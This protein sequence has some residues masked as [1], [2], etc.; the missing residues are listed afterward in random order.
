MAVSKDDYKHFVKTGKVSDS[1]LNDIAEKV[2]THS[3]LTP[4]E[5]SI[6]SD[7]TSQVESILQKQYSS[8][9]SPK[10]NSIFS[11]G[12]SKPL[13]E[14]SS[15]EELHKIA[16]A[17]REQ[18]PTGPFWQAFKTRKRELFLSQSPNVFLSKTGEELYGIPVNPRTIQTSLG[19]ERIK[20]DLYGQLFTRKQL[21][22]ID[23][24]SDT[25]NLTNKGINYSEF[26]G[27]QKQ[28]AAWIGFDLETTGLLKD[29]SNKRLG[30]H[31]G[32]L[33]M[34]TTIGGSSGIIEQQ[35]HLGT[36]DPNRPKFGD[37][38][39]GSIIPK[40]LQLQ[41]E[42]SIAALKKA[43]VNVSNNISEKDI[44]SS[45]IG[46]LEKNKNASLLGYNIKNFDIPFMEKIAE[47]HGLSGQLASAMGNRNVIDVADYAKAFLSERFYNKYVG[48]QEGSFSQMGRNPAGWQLE[49]VAHGFGFDG[50]TGGAHT[51]LQDTLMTE[52]VYKSLTGQNP[53][54][55]FNEQRYLEKMKALGNELTPMS[56]F[57]KLTTIKEGKRY[58]S[59]PKEAIPPLKLGTAGEEIRESLF[60]K[61]KSFALKNKGKLAIGVGLLAVGGLLFS[62]KD[63]EYN[64]IEALQHGNMAEGIRRT[65]T[66]FGSGYR[67]LPSS[68]MGVEIDP[69]ILSYKRDIIQTGKYKDVEA[70]L[71]RREKEQQEN[72]GSL[73]DSDFKAKRDLNLDT[74]IGINYRNRRLRQV[75]LEQFNINV[76]DAD[77]LVLKRK[78]IFG[79]F[80]KDI[81]IR[82][83][84]IDAPESASHEADPL[85]PV[86]IWQE[87][88]EAEES[89]EKLR[90]LIAQQKNLSLIVGGERTYGRY[91]GALIGDKSALNIDLASIGAV[92]AL[93]FGSESEDVLSRTLIESE[94]KKAQR[95]NLGIWSLARYK[96][97]DLVQDTIR[98]PI[99]FN[100]ITRIDKMAQ[101]LNLAAYGSFLEDLGTERRNLT[102]D[103]RET[104]KRIG[105]VLRKTHGP[106]KRYYNQKEGL[107][108][109][110][111]G[112][113]AKMI[114]GLT[115]FGSNS[116]ITAGLG[117]VSGEIAQK[118]TM[119]L[120]RG[121]AKKVKI[122]KP[123]LS[124]GLNK[125]KQELET[126]IERIRK[127]EFPNRPSRLSSS[128]WS[129]QPSVASAY[130]ANNRTRYTF[131]GRLKEKLSTLLGKPSSGFISKRQVDPNDIFMTSIS[132]YGEAMKAYNMKNQELLLEA[133]RKYWKGITDFAPEDIASNK[134]VLEVL[135]PNT[136]KA[137]VIWPLQDFSIKAHAD[138]AV[139]SLEASILRGQKFSGMPNSGTMAAEIREQLTEFKKDFAS[140]WDPARNIAASVFKGIKGRKA[141]NLL[142]KTEEWKTML[143]T[144]EQLKE[145]SYG[146]YGTT[147]LMEGTFRGEKFK[148]VKKVPNTK[149]VDENSDFLT[150]GP[151]KEKRIAALKKEASVMPIVQDRI[152]PS[153]YGFDEETNALYMELM[154]G[155]TLHELHQ[156]GTKIPINK[157]L[158]EI[159]QEAKKVAKQGV[160]NTDIHSNNIMYDP[161]TGK[162]SW[163]DWG[164]A[165]SSTGSSKE[166]LEKN[167]AEMAEAITKKLTPQ[168]KAKINPKRE[169]EGF[170]EM[171]FGSFNSM[172]SKAKQSF[173]DLSQNSVGV[174]FR[175]SR[176]AIKHG[177]YSSVAQ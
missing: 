47:R 21:E 38:I 150:G 1:I 118:M 74:I 30:S 60:S 70:E 36:L 80:S 17:G 125:G 159:K 174:S 22:G 14:A 132:F 148:F 147:Y 48:W 108:P 162:V 65:Y 97:V 134:K 157:I 56:E 155:K 92:S 15:L 12:Y 58:L 163:I 35:L 175:A 173:R 42:S 3:S 93:P 102:P 79:F 46:N 59:L 96:A 149:I 156:E 112:L 78:G 23:P 138:L 144:A 115:D 136:T 171:D 72:V 124:K 71:K 66:D 4:E 9:P 88:P 168:I 153:V 172:S 31:I 20:R 25:A 2:R 87:Q 113:G 177:S 106:R 119:T 91:V 27:K 26:L 5:L 130:A 63:D 61:G 68:L 160:K 161:E 29:F 39:E 81:Q 166:L 158:K 52:H 151:S 16:E 13:R 129:P 43:G 114:Q 94:Q 6:F 67:G 75:R 41:E 34:G 73:G 32:L 105:Y 154:P 128:Y 84:G 53:E 141:L 54:R 76:E 10:A 51:P 77:T 50:S 8:S 95:Q 37:Y 107:H 28:S 143:S 116:V 49:A 40:H 103:E 18:Y 44:L 165:E 90:E 110:S 133:T 126:F 24:I 82:L 145:L 137:D 104:A 142:K 123:E 45:F 101:N 152:A 7:K 89:S 131:I 57:E 19:E 64:T 55:V 139:Q 122:H 127:E 169:E 33:S 86:R 121:T 83:A 69:E 85:D 100:T 11:E 62:G 140:R 109:E 176:S 146:S 120:F 98:N 164:I 111:Q 117:K 170:F 135:L 167:S 99:T